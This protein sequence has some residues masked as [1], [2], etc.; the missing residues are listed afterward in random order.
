VDFCD[1]LGVAGHQDTYH[2]SRPGP[3]GPSSIFVLDYICTRSTRSP[4]RTTRLGWLLTTRRTT[5]RA[6]L[7]QCLAMRPSWTPGLRLLVGI[8]MLEPGAEVETRDPLIT[9]RGPAKSRPSVFLH[10]ST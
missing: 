4:V 10:S 8:D 7:S 6:R 2:S 9:K 3:S 5:R 1:A